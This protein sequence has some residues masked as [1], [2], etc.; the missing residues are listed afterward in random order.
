M[1]PS[2]HAHAALFFCASDACWNNHCSSGHEASFV[3]RFALQNSPFA[4]RSFC[5]TRRATAH[6]PSRRRVQRRGGACRPRVSDVGD[7]RGCGEVQY[8]NSGR[9]YRGRAARESSHE[10]YRRRVEPTRYAPLFTGTDTHTPSRIERRARACRARGALAPPDTSRSRPR[11]AQS[12]DNLDA[13]ETSRYVSETATTRC[14]TREARRRVTRQFSREAS[15]DVIHSG[16]AHRARDIASFRCSPRTR[17]RS[18][19]SSG[20]E[21][22]AI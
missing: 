10:L 8:P 7:D 5:G 14:N 12:A 1:T 22:L 18:R 9:V 6:T 20:R 19:G 15:R 16:V 4:C 21:T 13:P 2:Q 17:A 3:A 11:S